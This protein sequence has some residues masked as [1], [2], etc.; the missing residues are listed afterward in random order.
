MPTNPTNVLNDLFIDFTW[1]EIYNGGSEITGYQI[2]IRES[3]EYKWT[4]ELINC[5]GSQSAIVSSRT[6]SIPVSAL[7]A[8]PFTLDWGDSVYYKMTATNAVGT[9]GESQAGN[10]GILLTNPDTPF[11]LL[12]DASVTE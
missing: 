6:C 5:D 9:S 11:D 12:N 8:E 10:G 3:N 1:D 7:R 2:S 4:T